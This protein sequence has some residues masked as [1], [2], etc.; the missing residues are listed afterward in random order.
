[1]DDKVMSFDQFSKKDVME[2]PKTALKGSKVD[3]CKKET[4]VN[5]VKTADLTQLKTNEPDYSKVNEADS[6]EIANLQSVVTA[7]ER[8]LN[9]YKE[10]FYADLATKEKDL[11]SKREALNQAIAAAATTQTTTVAPTSTQQPAAP[12]ASQSIGGV[13]PGQAPAAPTTA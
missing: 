2:D 6:N 1:M 7:A 8:E 4:F 12:T 5:Q 10:K 13:T 9:D 3:P 11:Q